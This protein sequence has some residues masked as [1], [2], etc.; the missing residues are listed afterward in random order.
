MHRVRVVRS[1]YE[2]SEPFLG[3]I[4]EVIGHW[5]ADNNEDARDGYMVQFSD[6][7][8]IGVSENEVEDVAEDEVEGAAA[9]Q[10]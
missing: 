5:G 7:T 2:Q 8:I 3:R 4:G 1:F 6:G 9:A 10:T